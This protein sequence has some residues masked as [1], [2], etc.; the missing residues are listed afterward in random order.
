MPAASV[1]L[2]ALRGISMYAVRYC[3]RPSGRSV[4]NRSRMMRSCQGRSSKG[5][6]A[7]RPLEWRSSV[8]KNWTTAS[9]RSLPRRP[10]LFER[11]IGIVSLVGQV[12]LAPARRRQAEFSTQKPQ[13]LAG[14]L[15]GDGHPAVIVVGRVELL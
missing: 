15:H 4:P 10:E 6:P 5:R 13:I 2:P 12:D 11:T 8:L 14:V 7:Q 1:D 9:A 3:R